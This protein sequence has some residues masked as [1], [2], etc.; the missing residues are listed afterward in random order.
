M[1][2]THA[3]QRL[4]GAHHL[5][6]DGDPLGLAVRRFLHPLDDVGTERDPRD[7]REPLGLL[8]RPQDEDAGDDRHLACVGAA[9]LGEPLAEGREVE[10]GLRL[11]ELRARLHL[12]DSLG[13]V[14]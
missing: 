8:R 14:R 5:D 12:L 3:R 11:E 7:L 2:A 13:D 10:H 9:K 6:G 4:E 1:H